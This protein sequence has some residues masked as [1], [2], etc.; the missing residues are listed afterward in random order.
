M[1]KKLS[2]AV[3]DAALNHIKDNATSVI[4]LD[5]EPATRAAAVSAALCTIP[6][7]SGNFTLG[8]GT[9]NGRKV[10]V[11]ALSGTGGATGNHNHTAVISGTDL[12][13]VTTATE[14]KT[15]NNG[16]PVNSA[17]FALTLPDTPV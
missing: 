4:F 6:V 13:A 1:G 14:T 10:T 16:D 8:D 11:A 2:D 5:A 12:L 3:L 9:T 7:V 17:A 15:I